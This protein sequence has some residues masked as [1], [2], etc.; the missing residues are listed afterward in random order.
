[1]V[2]GDSLLTARGAGQL[3]KDEAAWTFATVPAW[4][5]D[6]GCC[7]SDPRPCSTCYTMTCLTIALLPPILP[8]APRLGRLH[9]R[10]VLNGPEQRRRRLPGMVV[11]IN[12]A[13]LA[14]EQLGK[15]LPAL[16]PRRR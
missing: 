12:A 7:V 6:G 3:G 11:L 1:M 4:G 5:S 10:I 8:L 16:R 2:T 15:L 14:G 9:S 13:G